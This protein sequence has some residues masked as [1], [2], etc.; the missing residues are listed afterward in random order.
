V[1]INKLPITVTAMPRTGSN[2]TSLVEI[3]NTIS[4]PNVTIHTEEVCNSVGIAE[5]DAQLPALFPN[6]VNNVLYIQGT[7]LFRTVE[8]IAMNGEVVMR[9]ACNARTCVLDVSGL[10]C[11]VYFLRGCSDDEVSTGK[12]VI[13]R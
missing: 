3:S 13:A 8:V 11:G 10:P 1:L 4:T 9:E 12:F 5:A 7:Q 6:P 2:A